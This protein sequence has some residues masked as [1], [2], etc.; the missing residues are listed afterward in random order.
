M[1]LVLDT[2]TLISAIGW[3]G[4]PRQIL[5]ALL[6]RRHALITTPDLLRELSRVL[7]YPRL[8]PLAAHPA[9]PAVLAWLHRPEHVVIPEERVRA[10]PADPAD[11]QV[12]EAALA[13]R[14]DAVVSGDR[15]L[16]ALRSFRGIPI[17]T[18]RAFAARHL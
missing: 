1:R 6:E 14:A 11:D 4:P 15:H 13:G 10:I 16:L 17:L 18:A 12:L 7:R 3:T 9:L 5:I 8:Q 2:N